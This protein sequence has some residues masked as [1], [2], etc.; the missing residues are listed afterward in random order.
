M[1]LAPVL[2]LMALVACGGA[3]EG[4]GAE[5]GA[6]QTQAVTCQL[7]TDTEG[8]ATATTLACGP[9]ASASDNLILAGGAYAYYL[10]FSGAPASAQCGTPDARPRPDG[11]LVSCFDICGEGAVPTKACATGTPCEVHYRTA[12]GSDAIP[13]Q[14]TCL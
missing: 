8:P 12:N 6:D 14:G 1:R 3:P 10:E 11:T 4:V 7:V 13:R 5:R 2:A 9:R